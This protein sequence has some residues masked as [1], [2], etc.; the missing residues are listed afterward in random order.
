MTQQ[1]NGAEPGNRRAGASI[2]DAHGGYPQVTTSWGWLLPAS[3]LL[4]D[5]STPIPTRPQQS[6][7]WRPPSGY[8]Q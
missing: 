2:E 3:R 6:A 7:A 5:C 4:N 1:S 8:G